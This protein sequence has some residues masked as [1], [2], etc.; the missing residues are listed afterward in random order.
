MLPAAHRTGRPTR[1]PEARNGK[2]QKDRHRT[3]SKIEHRIPRGTCPG[4]FEA[5]VELAQWGNTG[6][7]YERQH[8]A[9]L[10][11]QPGRR[12][13]RTYRE[14]R[15]DRVLGEMSALADERVHEL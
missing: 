9:N 12:R 2:T 3:T 7:E 15:K 5:L 6:H 13:E 4:G 1:T 10:I 8:P 11:K 14:Q